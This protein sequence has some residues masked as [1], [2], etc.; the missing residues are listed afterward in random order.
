[1]LAV[2][3]CSEGGEARAMMA[4]VGGEEEFRV[5]MKSLSV[6]LPV[7]HGRAWRGG[8]QPPWP[9]PAPRGLQRALMGLPGRKQ[10]SVVVVAEEF[11]GAAAR[12]SLP[13]GRLTSPLV[14]ALSRR[15]WPAWPC[16]PLRAQ[17]TPRG[18]PFRVGFIFKHA[19]AQGQGRDSQQVEQ[20][21]PKEEWS[22]I[23]ERPTG[24]FIAMRQWW[25]MNARAKASKRLRLRL[26]VFSDFLRLC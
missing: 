18:V 24:V 11:G 26:T 14:V 10:G 5:F 2:A 22:V 8:R 1:M 12:P 17:R 6:P 20:K 9:L 15:P 16:L 4:G 21:S 3:L 7:R 23:F 25:P 19:S 13:L